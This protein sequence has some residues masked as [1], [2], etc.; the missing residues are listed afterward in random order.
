VLYINTSSSEQKTVTLKNIIERETNE[1][2]SNQRS[3]VQALP[4]VGTVKRTDF[5]MNHWIT[6]DI[7]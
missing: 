2:I 4:S 6:E 3:D 7:R 1:T 5:K